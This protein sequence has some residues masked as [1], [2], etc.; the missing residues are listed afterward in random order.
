MANDYGWIEINKI[1]LYN[2]AFYHTPSILARSTYSYV[3][4]AGHFVCDKEFHLK[5]KE[6]KCYLVKYTLD[7][8]GFLNY[9]GKHYELKKNSLMI[10]DCDELQ[11]YFT[12]DCNSWEN[13]W[14]HFNGGMSR[15]YFNMIYQKFGPVFEMPVDSDIPKFIDQLIDWMEVEDNQ[16]EIKASPIIVQIL[17]SILLNAHVESNTSGKIGIPDFIENALAYIEKNYSKNILIE[18]IAEMVKVSV[19]HFSRLFKKSLGFSPYEYLLKYRMNK[20][21]TLLLHTKLPIEEIA[22]MVGFQDAPTFIRAFK[23][24][25]EITP[26]KYRNNQ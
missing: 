15:E 26:L 2:R 4:G 12:Y 1:L 7:G 25:E 17:T 13:K 19:F 22:V 3:L 24:L 8:A 23:R 21:K 5:R 14:V 16:F 6:Y 20:A 9:R 10:L 18:N 11:E